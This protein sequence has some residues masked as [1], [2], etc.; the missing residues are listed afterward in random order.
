M[1]I[2]KTLIET[3]LYISI[4]AVA[5]LWANVLLLGI[6]HEHLIY[7]SLQVFFSTWFIYQVSRW[8]YFKKGAYAHPQEWVLVWFQ[9]H[10]KFNQATIFF[11]G[12]LAVIF[13]LFL[14]WETILMLCFVGAI[15]VLYPVPFLKPFGIHTRL[16]D[17]PLIKI[18]LIAIV[19]SVTSV[20]LPASEQ[21]INILERKDVLLVFAEQFFFILF[22]TLP[23]DINDYEGDKRTK[24]KTIPTVVGVRE[25]KIIGAVIGVICA[26]G[27]LY[28]FMIE[29]WR[30]ISDVYLSEWTIGLLWLMLLF[31]Q[32]YTFFK[33]DKVNKWMIKIV[34]DGSMILY[35]LI[36][37]FTLR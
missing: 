4:A 27:L 8:I 2:F 17:F 37:F 35:L 20:L 25:S 29:N 5:F 3:N 23:F 24:I 15:S 11:S 36:V 34:Y 30:S 28:I 13:T 1:R 22:I 7:L 9:K 31:L 14:K 26:L 19:W 10:P 12:L 32:L 16:R 6:Q 21:R 33:S 18:F